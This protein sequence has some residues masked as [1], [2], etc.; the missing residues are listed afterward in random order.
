MNARQTDSFLCAKCRNPYEVKDRIGRKDTCP[1][2]DA[3]L[4]TCLN[5]R[6]YNPRAHNECNE[7]QAEWVR[8]KDRSN[9]CDYFE[10]SRGAGAGP[11]STAR[12][13]DARA[14]FEDLFKK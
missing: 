8:E 5:C 14:R 3:D 9:F 2:C 13:N 7:T 11:P 1:K 4:H 6:H 10:P 12:Q